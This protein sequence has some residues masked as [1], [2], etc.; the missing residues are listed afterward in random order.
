MNLKYTHKDTE[1]GINGAPTDQMGQF[2][3]QNK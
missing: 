1:A 2:E 3:H